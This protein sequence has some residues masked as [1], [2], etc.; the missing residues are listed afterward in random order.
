MERNISK[1]ESKE[2]IR[3]VVQAFCLC[4]ISGFDYLLVVDIGGLEKDRLFRV[5]GS[6]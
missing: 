5:R 4:L 3:A 6:Q 1:T 2:N